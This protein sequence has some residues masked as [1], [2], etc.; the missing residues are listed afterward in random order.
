MP[1]K[2]TASE[3]TAVTLPYR[4]IGVMSLAA[5]VT[6]S[7]DLSTA[8]DQKPAIERSA[9][10]VTASDSPPSG[11]AYTQM[12]ALRKREVAVGGAVPQPVARVDPKELLSRRILSFPSE[13][14]TGPEGTPISQDAIADALRFLDLLPAGSPVPHVSVAADGEVNFFRRRP[15]LFLDIGFYGDGQIHYYA[16]VETLEIDAAGSLPF[17]G[18]SLPY[19]LVGPLTAE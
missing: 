4:V 15:G 6:A 16:R 14:H 13:L 12:T 18:R 11:L 19:E 1:L 3:G 10:P 2:G 9:L 7:P 5:L 17:D 8:L